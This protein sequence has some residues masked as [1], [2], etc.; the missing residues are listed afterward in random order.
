MFVKEICA[1]DWLDV[2]E[3]RRVLQRLSDDLHLHRS[4]AA[5]LQFTHPVGH[6]QL[7]YWRLT[8]SSFLW[9]DGHFG[10]AV[11]SRLKCVLA[12]FHSAFWPGIFRPPFCTPLE[13]T[14]ILGLRIIWASFRRVPFL[15]TLFTNVRFQFLALVGE[16][17]RLVTEE[18]FPVFSFSRSSASSRLSLPTA[19]LFA[20]GAV[21][22]QQRRDLFFEE[23]VHDINF[24]R[25][26]VWQAG[27][28][29]VK[30]LLFHVVVAC[31]FHHD[32]QLCRGV[33]QLLQAL[34]VKGVCYFDFA[35]LFRS[36]SEAYF[37]SRISFAS[38]RVP[39]AATKLVSV[40]CTAL[41]S[42]RSLAASSTGTL[43]THS[44]MRRQNPKKDIF[45]PSCSGG[46][47]LGSLA[48]SPL[49]VCGGL[50]AAAWLWMRPKR[51]I[52]SASWPSS[53][54][55]LFGKSIQQ[56]LQ[57]FEQRLDVAVGNAVVQQLGDGLHQPIHFP[58][59]DFGSDHLRSASAI[60]RFSDS[61]VVAVIGWL[62][63]LLVLVPTC[64]LTHPLP[65]PST[66]SSSSSASSSTSTSQS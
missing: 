17:P 10:P 21:V 40:E 7:L 4:R 18:T 19:A 66:S 27:D 2:S 25:E 60:Q 6:N 52:R 51:V 9:Q 56:V 26:R 45:L 11:Y 23:L 48:S 29:G 8:G 61:A 57:V 53:S 35:H 13:T 37:F 22:G 47:S 59:S 1:D 50:F 32:K 54:S 36:F 55:L 33:L 24:Q 28:Y 39:Q 65:P 44:F 20:F 46:F 62:L 38:S 14:D 49:L 41:I 63:E 43:N 15:F 12:N 58:D 31:L 5:C 3:V 30:Q 42:A 34:T 64:K 16:M